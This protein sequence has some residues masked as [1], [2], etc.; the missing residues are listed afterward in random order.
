M[1]VL[2]LRPYWMWNL[3]LII[4][5]YQNRYTCRP[6]SFFLSFFLF[7]SY[8]I[9]YES[10]SRITECY[11]WHLACIYGS[12]L[13]LPGYRNK[14]METKLIAQI[15]VYLGKYHATNLNIF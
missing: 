4:K 14:R 15:Y 6:I 2:I 12:F 8:I 1:V 5:I 7:E 3:H 13:E 10:Q 9:I 11:L